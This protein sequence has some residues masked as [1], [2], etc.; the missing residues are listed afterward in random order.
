MKN[1]QR[2]FLSQG[3]AAN[4]YLAMAELGLTPD[5]IKQAIVSGFDPYFRDKSYLN[6]IAVEFL[7]SEFVNLVRVADDAWSHL[8]F[9][10]VLDVYGHAEALDATKTY[11]TCG[12]GEVFVDA[13][14]TEYW[15]AMY[16]EVPKSDLDIYDFKFEAFRTLGPL[17]EACLQPL[18]RELLCHLRTVRGKPASLEVLSSLSLGNVVGELYDTSGFPEFYAPKPWGLRLSQ[19]RNIAQHHNSSVVNGA[20]V[21]VYGE[22][23]NQKSITL[24]RRDLMA[25][26]HKVMAAFR[27]IKLARTLFVLDRMPQVKPYMP[28]IRQR[29]DILGFGFAVAAST[30]GF[31]IDEITTTDASA[32]AW[33]TDLHPYDQEARMAHASQLVHR[34]WVETRAPQVHIHYCDAD[35][36]S[37]VTFGATARD[38]EQLWDGQ[39]TISEFADRVSIRRRGQYDAPAPGAT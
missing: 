5:E 16:S 14:L 39:I 7:G 20:I 32:S 3:T 10:H 2:K 30:Q 24:S 25:V 21:G 13:A 27:A 26:L 35:Q 31:Q 1:L 12:G 37:I 6:E 33:L 9:Q 34:L 22:A 18:L 38:C 17:I 4:P 23:P 8:L 29:P 28:T 36:T 15:S 11:Q 19:W